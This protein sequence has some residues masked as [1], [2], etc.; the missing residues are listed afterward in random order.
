M[1]V[2]YGQIPYNKMNVAKLQEISFSNFY[3]LIL[4][5]I[6]KKI[7]ILIPIYR[8]YLHHTRKRQ[9]HLLYIVRNKLGVGL[10]QLTCIWIAAYILDITT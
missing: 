2:S 5:N 6:K 4:Y 1:Q 8:D 10:C 3:C 9:K 7:L